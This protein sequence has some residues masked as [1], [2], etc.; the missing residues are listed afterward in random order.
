MRRNIANGYFGTM[1]G[2]TIVSHQ[3]FI[4]CFIII[5]HKIFYEVVLSDQDG[6]LLTKPSP[7]SFSVEANRDVENPPKKIFIHFDILAGFQFFSSPCP[8]QRSTGEILKFCP[9][10]PP[11][12][13]PAPP[14]AS[15]PRIRRPESGPSSAI[16]VPQWANFQAILQHRSQKL[17]P[18][19]HNPDANQNQGHGNGIKKAQDSD[20]NHPQI[21]C[22]GNKHA[23]DSS[24]HQSTCHGEHNAASSR[25]SFLAK[26]GGDV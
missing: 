7:E 11:S 18:I 4:F 6:S 20:K 13:I 9:E 23:E 26:T 2:D 17:P 8:A 15:R 25:L 21:S 12:R 5:I 10:S 19:I 24:C 16:K 14:P 22:R 1:L 3:V